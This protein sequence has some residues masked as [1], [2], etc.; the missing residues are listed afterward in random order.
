MI[1]LTQLFGLLLLIQFVFGSAFNLEILEPD[2]LEPMVFISGKLT[3]YYNSS[4]YEQ[5][6]VCTNG[7]L[8]IIEFE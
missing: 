3:D 4:V 7:Q 2:V 8:E 6:L 5:H 1:K